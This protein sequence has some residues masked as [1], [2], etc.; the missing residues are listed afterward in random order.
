ML[1]SF[2]QQ[3]E[4]LRVF[5]EERREILVWSSTSLHVRDNLTDVQSEAADGSGAQMIVK[6]IRLSVGPKIN[7]RSC[8]V[9]VGFL[10]ARFSS[11]KLR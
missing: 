3:V 8:S 6:T 10:Q 7:S 4:T 9:V 1:E 11:T 2:D 5:Y